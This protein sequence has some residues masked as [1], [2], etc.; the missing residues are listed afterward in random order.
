MGSQENRL[1]LVHRV[2]AARRGLKEYAILVT[3][4][5]SV[6]IQLPPSRNSFMLRTEIVSGSA[7]RT[8]I[9]PRRLEDYS[10][11]AIGSLESE[12]QNFSSVHSAVKKVIIGIGGFFPVY[13]FSFAYLGQ[14]RDENLVFYA[15]PLET[16]ESATDKKPR[17]VILKAYAETI[18][19][20]Y[21]HVLPAGTIDDVGLGDKEKS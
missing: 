18:F 16:Y 10:R 15:V 14:E 6:F 8:N 11:W 20:L 2:L 4:K 5:R 21:R 9:Q 3:E 17:E 13:H 7:G 19:E 1:G 12:P